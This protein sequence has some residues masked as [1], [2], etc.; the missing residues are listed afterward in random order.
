[1]FGFFGKGV[2][3]GRF[4]LEAELFRVGGV[5]FCKHGDCRAGRVFESGHY[6]K[7]CLVFDFVLLLE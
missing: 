2:G 4:G 3:C 1:L 5:K 6:G 7:T